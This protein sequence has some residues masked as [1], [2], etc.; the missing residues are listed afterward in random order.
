MSVVH[1]YSD[2]EKILVSIDCII[3]GF[4][5]NQLNL[6]LFKRK[7]DPFKGEWSLVGSF[8]NPEE[9]VQNA[10][11]RVLQEYTGIDEIFMEPLAWYGDVDRDPGGRV[12]SMAYYSLVRID[13]SK[14]IK[15]DS[16]QAKWFA[17]D[18]I[19]PLI[20]DHDQMVQD[21]LDKLRRKARYEPI[22]FELLPEKFTLPHLKRFYDAIYQKDLDRRNFRKKIISMGIL[23]KLDEKDKSTSKKGA[24]LYQFDADKYEELRSKGFNFVI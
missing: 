23:T 7:I 21:A 9:D 8:V 12:I 17:I 6:L 24:Y 18:E 10:A 15:A 1:T 3:F 13:E 14:V 20:L 2:N 11:V 16:Y 4:D 19:P 22:G 5:Q